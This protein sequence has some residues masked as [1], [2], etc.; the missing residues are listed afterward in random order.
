MQIYGQRHTEAVTIMNNIT[1]MQ[2]S[3]EIERLFGLKLGQLQLHSMQ[4]KIDTLALNASVTRQNSLTNTPTSPSNKYNPGKFSKFDAT[5][6][7]NI[8]L[9][10]P[11]DL[12]KGCQ[13]TV[14]IG[15][16]HP[17]TVT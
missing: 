8:D 13:L 3:V 2:S 7:Y 11:P 10:I 4:R 15:E 16:P 6:T 1:Q 5:A 12:Y 9:T 14:P 17:E